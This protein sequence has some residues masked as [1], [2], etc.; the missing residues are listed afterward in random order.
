MLIID[1]HIQTWLKKDAGIMNQLR[2]HAFL[3]HTPN[4]HHLSI[5]PTTTSVLPFHLPSHSYLARPNVFQGAEGLL[6]LA[7][8]GAGEDGAS[9]ACCWE[10]VKSSDG[11]SSRYRISTRYIKLKTNVFGFPANCPII[12]SGMDIAITIL[13]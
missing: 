7:A 10:N 1:I 4:F 13:V 6:P 12:D 3:S 2:I 8:L 5:T 11:F 9:G